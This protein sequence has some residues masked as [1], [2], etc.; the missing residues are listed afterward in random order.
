MA[1]IVI[2]RIIEVHPIADAPYEGGIGNVVVI[3]K[4]AGALPGGLGG[5]Q[6]D[7]L[8]LRISSTKE[9]IHIGEELLGD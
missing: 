1:S 3:C 9:K 7:I 8:L 6:I 5:G 4:L 2:E